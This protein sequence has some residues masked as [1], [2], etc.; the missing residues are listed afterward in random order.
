MEEDEETSK[1][2]PPW[3]ELEYTVRNYPH[4]LKSPT[5]IQRMLTGPDAYIQFAN[6]QLLI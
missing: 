1:A 5:Q 6:L 2:I 3:V 4:N